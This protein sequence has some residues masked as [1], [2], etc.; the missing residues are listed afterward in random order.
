LKPE[1]IVQTGVAGG[2]SLLY[3]ASLL[4]LIAAPVDALVIGIDTI[5]TPSARE[6]DH[7]RIRLLKGSS[8][9]PVVLGRLKELV[10]ARAGL[11]SLDSDHSKNHV[12]AEL[13][14][15]RNF[16]AVGSY[17]VVEDT[18]INGHPVWP[19]FGLGPYE[20]IEEFLKD[21]TDF[22]SDDLWKRNFF[23]F[24][25]GGW[26]RRITKAPADCAN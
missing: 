18:N 8:T 5:L 13:S 11:V 9:D 25:Q 3:F 10:S 6:L 14:A 20:A 4:D 24:H 26:L 16:V 7:P 19:T 2:G 12:L 21:N 17:L 23:S 15:Y 22:V 1:F